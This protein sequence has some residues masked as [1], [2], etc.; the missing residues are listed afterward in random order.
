MSDTINLEI[1]IPADDEGY[2]LLQCSHCGSFF[3]ITSEDLKDESVFNIY[4][5]CC[6]L[7]SDNYYTEDVIEL[8]QTKVYN[9]AMDMIYD[10][11]KDMERHNSSKSAVKFKAGNK[12]KHEHENPIRTRIDELKIMQYDCCHRSAKV[13]PL[14][15]MSASYCPF[16][17]VIHFG[18]E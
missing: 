16:C 14:I 5:P 6:G 17:G 1:S 11:F 18:D 2:I 4:C 10:A 12:P 13:S 8:A 9:L 7:I 3:K 15:Q